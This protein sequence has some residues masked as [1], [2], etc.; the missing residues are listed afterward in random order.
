M[1][2]GKSGVFDKGNS[3]VTAKCF[4]QV[5]DEI[6][7]KA[8]SVPQTLLFDMYLNLHPDSLLD[9]WVPL[10]L[11]L[12]V[13]VLLTDWWSTAVWAP[14][15]FNTLWLSCALP[16]YILLKKNIKHHTECLFQFDWKFFLYQ[17]WTY[18]LWM[19]IRSGSFHPCCSGRHGEERNGWER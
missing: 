17:R 12:T 5:R 9:S 19:Y 6:S 13:P 1:R 14:E 18:L 16:S 7:C 8:M 11:V 10:V 3:H 2:Q 4:S 15:L